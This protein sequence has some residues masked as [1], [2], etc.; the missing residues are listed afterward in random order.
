[1]LLYFCLRNHC[2][3]LNSKDILLYLVLEIYSFNFAFESVIFLKKFF[4][5]WFELEIEVELLQ[6]Q[7]MGKIFLPS[8]DFFGFFV[9]IQITTCM[10]PFL[11]SLLCF[12]KRFDIIFL[13][14]L[15]YPNQYHFI[16]SLEI[17]FV[18]FVQ[19]WLF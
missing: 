5:M 12:N 16:Q 10:S 2:L 19:V 18:L 4:L 6:H 15:Q 14:V 1:M 7:L 11:T 3:Y 8:V 9:K 13:L 17:S